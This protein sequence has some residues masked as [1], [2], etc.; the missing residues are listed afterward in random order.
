MDLLNRRRGGFN[1]VRT[2][3]FGAMIPFATAL[4]GLGTVYFDNLGQ[5]IAAMLMCGFFSASYNG[6]VYSVIVHQAGPRLRGLAVSLVQLGANLIGV[7]AG[8]YLIGAVSEA[9]GGTRGVAWGIGFAMIFVAWGG[10]HLLL[11]TRSIRIGQQGTELAAA[12]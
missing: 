8:T 6:P 3:L 2:A 4:T 9:V 11:A 10:L 7:G 12:D 1:P 5:V